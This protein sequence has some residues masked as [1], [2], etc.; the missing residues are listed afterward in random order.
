MSEDVP[1]LAA[2]AGGLPAFEKLT[3]SFYAKVPHHAIL[4]PVFG[5]IWVTSSVGHRLVASLLPWHFCGLG[6]T[7]L[8]VTQGRS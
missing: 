4:A 8:G 6:G 3:E 2:W 1:T 5:V 7:A